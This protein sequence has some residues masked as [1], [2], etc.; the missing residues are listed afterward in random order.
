MSGGTFRARRWADAFLAVCGEDA[1]E[2]FLYFKAL[3]APV[4]SARGVLFGGGAAE[5]LEMILRESFSA[6]SANAGSPAEYA[7]RFICLLA[8]KKRVKHIDKLSLLI[9]RKLDERKGLIVFS[10]ETAVPVNSEF[11]EEIAGMIKEKTGAVSVKL[12]ARVRPEL[13]G[14]YLLRSDMFYI[15]ASLKGQ[16]D[17][18]M[19]ELSSARSGGLHGG[20]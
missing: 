11:T 17:K 14:G 13:L 15:D 4:K 18:M 19:T 8:E 1:E 10:V 20:I 3:A 6:F 9:E 12:A 2:A 7:I 5:K 16:I